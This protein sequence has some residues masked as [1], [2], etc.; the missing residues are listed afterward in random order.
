MPK[1]VAF[2]SHPPAEQVRTTAADVLV[3]YLR[4]LGVEFV[5]GIPGGAIEP[6]YNA[7]ARSG[8]Q[9]PRAV[10][11]RHETGSVFMAEGYQRRTGTLGVCCAT[12]GPG[13]TNLITGVASA[14]AN[15]VPLLVL[16]AQTPLSGFGRQAF[17]ESSC[18]GV[19]VLAMLE[20]CT[21]YNSLVSHPEQL[22]SKLAAAV[23]SAFGA[24]SGPVHLS[25]PVD[26]L[27]ASVARGERFALGQQL[28]K[29]ANP[30]PQGVARLTQAL[31]DA[32]SPV[33]LV[34]DGAIGAAGFVQAIAERL[35]ARV[36]STPLGKG[37]LAPR[38]PANM[39]VV[40]FAGH[41]TAYRTLFD[42]NVDL[43][44]SIGAH[45]SE[46]ATS[47]W[48][49]RMTTGPRMIHVDQREDSFLLAPFAEHI[50]GDLESIL[51]AV[52]QQLPSGLAAAP[53]A[54]GPGA[55]EVRS[56][57]GLSFELD[58]TR[59]ATT[60]SDPLHPAHLMWELPRWL[61]ANTRYLA[62]VGASFAWAIHYL[63]PEGDAAFA[64]RSQRDRL[65]ETCIDFS[66]MGWAIG[67]SVGA[68]LGL[69]DQPVV[70]ITGDGSMLMNGQEITVA[71]QESLPVLFIVLNDGA[72]GMVKHGQQLTGAAPVGHA[73]PP[74]D[75]VG[76]ARALGVEAFRMDSAADLERLPEVDLG[77]RRAPFLIDVHIDPGAVP[78]IMRRTNSLR[79][80]AAAQTLPTRLS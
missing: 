75:F 54:T 18:T 30:W 22:E 42:P 45:L 49:P 33:L 37:T 27:G 48:D 41:Q 76:F 16:T 74:V 4:E 25:I 3:A 47:G 24:R 51:S 13:A 19:N 63:H 28:P 57:V 31:T 32:T 69:R 40:G 58:D 71:V 17:Q 68:A 8:P 36:V 10:T 64:P 50:A 6:L 53:R 43:I 12:T 7:L 59:A 34:G 15:G 11:A 23:L 78:P 62:D 66:S 26:V 44:V 55:R 52:L 70:C 77:R 80:Q 67:Y 29:A 1:S 2:S 61:P 79:G 14:Y 65:F 56:V 73:L 21:R 5:F 35:P 60:P 38:H 46:W 9:G 39:G 20:P 72:L